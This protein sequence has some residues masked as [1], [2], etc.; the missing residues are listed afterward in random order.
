MNLEP[1]TREGKKAKVREDIIH[2]SISLFEKRGYEQTTVDMISA[3][4]G[5]ST[6]TFFRYFPSKDLAAFP[7][8]LEYV[9]TFR[10]LL[11]KGRKGRTPLETVRQGLKGIAELY[12]QSWKDHLKYQNIISSS[13]HTLARSI[14]LDA[15]WENGIADL[16]KDGRHLS[17]EQTHRANLIAGI[18]MGA[19]KVVMEKWYAGDCRENLVEMGETAMDLVENG[20]C[21]NPLSL[22]K[23]TDR[24]AVK[25]GAI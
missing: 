2:A 19:V 8:H 10:K 16:W 3:A 1:I 11:K 6:R 15:D 7:L 20:I 25:D 18:I 9:A 12:Q 23:N 22:D 5:V 13:P 21:K 4:A 17:D 24:A 14:Q